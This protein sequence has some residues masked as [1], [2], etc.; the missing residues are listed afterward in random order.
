MSEAQLTSEIDPPLPPGLCRA[1]SAR[2]R[3][4]TRFTRRSAK[5]AAPVGFEHW[6][7][8]FYDAMDSLFDYIGG[9]PLILD[10]RVEDVAHERFAQIADYY[11]ARKPRL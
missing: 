5:D 9:A 4:A 2:R 8:L 6:L 7:P 11:E 10:A 3:A 1:N